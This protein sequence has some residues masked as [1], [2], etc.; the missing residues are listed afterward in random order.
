MHTYVVRILTRPE[1]TAFWTMNFEADDF[2][3]AAEQA[4][5]YLA[6]YQEIVSIEK[7]WTPTSQQGNAG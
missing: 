5:P 7:A 1:D 2:A 3:H 6:T 4:E